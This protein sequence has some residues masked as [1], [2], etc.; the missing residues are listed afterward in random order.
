MSLLVIVLGPLSTSLKQSLEKSL[1]P[2]FALIE[3]NFVDASTRTEWM[4]WDSNPSSQG[5]GVGKGAAGCWLAHKEAWTTANEKEYE[6]IL[7]LEDDAR[8]TKYGARYLQHVVEEFMNS[9]LRML[10]LG[11]HESAVFLHPM[12]MVVSGNFRTIVKHFLDRIILYPL[13]PRL[14]FNRFPY[15][16]HGYLLKKSMLPILIKNSP[17]FIFPVDVFLNSISQVRKNKAAA[18]RTPMIVQGNERESLINRYG[19]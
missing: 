16:A 14:A 2:G 3:V 13:K 17:L 4:D 8:I 10:H 11:D 6:N 5:L 18:I 1:I 12:R 7:I 9:E 15:S 19:R